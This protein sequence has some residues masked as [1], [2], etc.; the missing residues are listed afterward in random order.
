MA[1]HKE[2]SIGELAKAI[3]LGQATVTGILTRLENRGLVVR[4]RSNS[5][6][7]RVFVRT[8]KDCEHL[9]KAAPPPIQET[10]IDQFNNLLDWE[11]TLILSA[12]Q[13]LVSM[14]NASTISAEPLLSTDP[15]IT[16]PDQIEEPVN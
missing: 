2:I 12:L 1:K 14:M 11:Q 6:K 5:D 10:F 7:R 3:S 8:T 13:R 9:L 15:L 16:A 4:R